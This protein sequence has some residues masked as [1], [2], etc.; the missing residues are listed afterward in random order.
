MH[1]KGIISYSATSEL[2]A[3]AQFENS[4]SNSFL[5]KTLDRSFVLN[6]LN[7]NQDFQKSVRKMKTW[8][9]KDYQ[10][11]EHNSHDSTKSSSQC[12]W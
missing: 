11:C 12:T 8:I 3:R 1:T 9:R 5:H 2:T 7:A 4:G 10:E 6:V